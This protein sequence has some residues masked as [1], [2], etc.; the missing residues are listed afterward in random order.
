VSVNLKCIVVCLLI[1]CV[2]SLSLPAQGGQFYGGRGYLHTNSA[3]LLPPGALDISLY[4]RAYMTTVDVSSEWSTISD[5]TSAFTASF[6]FTR[7][8]ELGFTQ[9]LYQDLNN[10]PRDDM[11]ITT[12]I[13]GDTYIR[14]KIGGW[15][16]GQKMFMSVLPALRYRVAKYHDV[17]FEPYE[18]KAV[19]AEFIG[20]WSYYWKPLYPDE[21]KSLHLNLGYLNHNDKDSPTE[22]SQALNYL[23]CMMFPMRMF[24]VGFELYGNKFLQR[25]D[26]SVLGREDWAYVTPLA[27]YKPFKGFQFT[28]GVDLLLQGNENTTEPQPGSSFRNIDDYPNYAKW[29]ITGRINFAP[30][31][32]FYISPT[33]VRSEEPGTG[34]G[35]TSLQRS[36]GGG[37]F[38]FL[39]RDDLFKWAIEEHTGGV[40]AVD[41]DLEKLRQERIKA[42]EDLKKLKRKLEEKK[43]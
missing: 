39:N 28:L 23:V 18:S 10:T 15:A 30:S 13:P 42:E 14:F 21:D 27:R 5:G 22:S 17:H 9:I 41:L 4:A 25:P 35:R 1:A 3:L 20:A 19:E 24:D 38:D 16:I 34:Q 36:E 32:A 2:L 29:R 11:E 26:V 12:L 33:F 40:S 8:V 7:R 43:K 31:T 37:G 6:G